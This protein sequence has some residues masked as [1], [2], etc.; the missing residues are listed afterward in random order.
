ML[1]SKASNANYLRMRRSL[2]VQYLSNHAKRSLH[3]IVS[4]LQTKGIDETLTNIKDDMVGLINIGLDIDSYGS[5]YKLNDKI[6]KLTPYQQIVAKETNNTVLVK[7]R[8]RHKL[9]H[10]DHKY[11]TLIDYAFSGKDKCTEFEI[12]TIDLL[13]NELA[14]NGIHLGGTRRPD[15][16][17]SHNQNGVIIDNKA[18]AKGFTITRSMADEMTRYVQENNDR[19]PERN[20]NMWWQNFGPN[21]NH[22]NF[23]F[24]SS[25]FKGEV[26][27]MLENIKQSTGV[28]G[29][30]LTAENLLYFAD[31]IKGDEMQKNEFIDLFGAGKEIVCPNDRN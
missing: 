27:Y 15:G 25:L 19:N 28:D 29:C 20:K 3:E 24:I 13:V 17:F 12:Y 9:Q 30:A 7:D 10:I 8:V 11:L 23:V 2:I 21:V 31:A 6:L 26:E 16:I 5:F 18:Y 4:F 1:A 14:F 22:F